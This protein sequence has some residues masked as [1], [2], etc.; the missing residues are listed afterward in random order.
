MVVRVEGNVL[1]S[2]RGLAMHCGVQAVT[3]LGHK[4]I[5]EGYPALLLPF[6]SNV[7]LSRVNQTPPV[8]L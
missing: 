1:I 3:I 6:H 5:Q 7:F 4:N 2:R 8:H